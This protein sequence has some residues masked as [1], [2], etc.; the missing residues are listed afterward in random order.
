MEKRIKIEGDSGDRIRK[1]REIYMRKNKEKG[2]NENNLLSNIIYEARDGD[3]SIL[4][5]TPSPLI[6]IF[7]VS[8]FIVTP[9]LV[10]IEK[11][12]LCLE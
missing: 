5:L 6:E 3:K 9:I 11:S 12:L 10:S 2:K 4:V 1:K 7:L 8:I